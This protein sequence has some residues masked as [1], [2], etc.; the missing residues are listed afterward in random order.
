MKIQQ[1]KAKSLQIG[2]QIISSAQCLT[3]RVKAKVLREE[4]A[5]T[6]IISA[7]LVS[8]MTS[9][10]HVLHVRMTA[11]AWVTTCTVLTTHASSVFIT[12]VI[13]VLSALSAYQATAPMDIAKETSRTDLN[14]ILSMN[15]RV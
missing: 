10:I 1:L 3:L 14:V 6:T 5:K 11:T 9:L 15:A 4:L 8:A 7:Q 12:M 13:I 2:V